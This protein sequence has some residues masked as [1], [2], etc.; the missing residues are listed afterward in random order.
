MLLTE[1]STVLPFPSFLSIQEIQE[2]IIR[3]IR[4]ADQLAHS[5]HYDSEGVRSRL[6]QVDSQCEDFLL[7][8]DARRKNVALAVT[9]FHLS[10]TV[11]TLQG[12]FLDLFKQTAC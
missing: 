7:R 10:Q 2:T 3:L 11:S 4:T 1:S 8:M 12:M 5:A 9:F 6:T